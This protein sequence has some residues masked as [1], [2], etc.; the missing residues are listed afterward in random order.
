LRPNTE[1]S[2][3]TDCNP[4]PSLNHNHQLC[5][6]TEGFHQSDKSDEAVIARAFQRKDAGLDASSWDVQATVYLDA[7]VSDS[8]AERVQV[9]SNQTKGKS[10]GGG[11][12][13]ADG[14]ADGGGGS[15][16]GGMISGTVAGTINGVTVTAAYVRS[17]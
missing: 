5:P 17:V 8:I 15:G 11:A 14:D 1:G 4:N 3:G 2:D 7:G 6:N 13:G 16:G 10:G 9:H 12:D